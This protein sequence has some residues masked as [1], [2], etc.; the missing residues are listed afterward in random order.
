[1]TLQQIQPNLHTDTAVVAIFES[2]ENAEAAVKELAQAKFDIK[3][4]S[5]VGRGFHSDEAVTGFYNAGNRIKFWGKN[6]AF[7][8]GLW[9]LL[10]GGLF[11]TVPVIGPV[12]VLGHLAVIVASV[13]EGAVVVGG[14]SAFGAALC[15]IGIPKDSVL[16]YE[17]TI[18]A[19]DFLVLVHGSDAEVEDARSILKNY[20]A[21]QIDIHKNIQMTEHV[22]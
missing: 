10:F 14:L 15:S 18:K 20:H 13:I 21:T 22:Q 17:K 4:I 6:G 1:V 9:G 16:H 5:V 12:M 19:D 11:L 2:H 3:K 7:W 8:G